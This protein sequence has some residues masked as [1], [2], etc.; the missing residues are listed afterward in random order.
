M[1]IRKEELILGSEFEDMVHLG[2]RS[3]NGRDFETTGH[4]VPT[5]GN[6]RA[7]NGYNQWTSPSLNSVL[8]HTPCRPWSGTAHIQGRIGLSHLG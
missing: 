1:K 3:Y 2:G 4:V 6:Q 8:G 5:V 7:I